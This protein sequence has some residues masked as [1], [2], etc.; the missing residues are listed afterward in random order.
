MFTKREVM[1]TLNHKVVLY[2]VLFLSIVSVLGQL[3]LN[4]YKYVAQKYTWD[5]I[6]RK[7][8]NIMLDTYKKP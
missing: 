8:D 4:N 3:V 2:V 1:K 7:Y 5:N 6:I